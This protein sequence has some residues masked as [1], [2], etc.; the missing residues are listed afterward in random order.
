M[1]IVPLVSAGAKDLNCRLTACHRTSRNAALQRK[2]AHQ[3]LVRSCAARLQRGNKG[4]TM[5]KLPV[6]RSIESAYSF[7]FRHFFAVLGI[8]WFPYVVL[9]AILALPAITLVPR[10]VGSIETGAFDFSMLPGLVGLGL[11][12]WL[13]LM[14][15]GAM[16]RVGLLR[17]ALGLAEGRI[18]LYFSLGAPVWRMLGALILLFVILIA[19]AAASA[20]IAGI[21]WGA[22]RQFLSEGGAALAGGI[23]VFV[24]TC[25]WIYA[26]VRIG[27]FL[28]A[29]VVAEEE[30]GIGRAWTLGRGNF[31][32][33]VVV[34]IASILPVAI[35][36]GILSS[37]VT[38]FVPAP[39]TEPMTFPEAVRMLH[40]RLVAAGPIG[41]LLQLVYLMLLTGLG[42]GAVAGAYR[43]IASQQAGAAPAETS[44]I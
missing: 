22:S 20:A 17:K 42:T 9:V 43:A 16:V 21:I 4:A 13:G 28:P 34:M 37:L 2:W 40:D 35:A 30:I 8:V 11:L 19:M 31:W 10:M 38:S 24:A 14:V 18:F 15:A 27:F 7:A 3:L 5:P 1:L 44:H 41:A 29:V 36:F 6:G 12:F 39:M 25:W 32:R 23:A 26:A 33:I